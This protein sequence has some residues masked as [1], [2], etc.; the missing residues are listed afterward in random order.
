[1]KICKQNM[2]V[3]RKRKREKDLEFA[4]G[5]N[6]LEFIASEGWLNRRKKSCRFAI[7]TDAWRPYTTD[8]TA[9]WEQTHLPNILSQHDF[10]DV[11]NAD[12]F[13]LLFN[14]FQRKHCI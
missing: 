13:V 11:L 8:M 6:I 9:L 7:W 4:K 14:N 12:E 5:I 10:K 1:M 3:Q 2:S